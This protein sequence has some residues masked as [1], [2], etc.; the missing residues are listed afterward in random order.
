MKMVKV[1]ILSFAHMHAYSYAH[2]LKQL[3]NVSLVGVADDN[4]KR[5]QAAAKQFK[6]KFF[7]KCVDLVKEVDAVIITSENVWHKDLTILSANAGKHVLCEK[8][9][10]ISV[11]DAQ[12]MIDVCKKNKVKLQ[13]AFPCRF[14]PAIKRMKEV[15]DEG[16]L[17]KILAINATNH[18]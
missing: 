11:A 13:T 1:G 2:S 10:S 18:G 12:T 6:T 3:F 17:G 4:V 14:A 9:I 5:G 8:P 7:K 15:I 16:K